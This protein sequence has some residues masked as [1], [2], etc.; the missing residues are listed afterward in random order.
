MIIKN[1]EE[2]LRIRCEAVR[3]EEI[4]ELVAMLEKELDHSTYIG[5][6]G[7]GLA[8]IQVGTPKNIAIVRLGEYKVDLVNC[9]IEKGY[10]KAIFRDE[11]CLSFPGRV[12]DTMRYQEI[13]VVNNLVY[14]HSFVASGLMA[15]VVAHEIDHMNG[16]LLPDN[17]IPKIKKKVGPNDSCICGSGRKYKKCC[18]NKE[19]YNGK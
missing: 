8:A 14:P 5:Q 19:I 10:D 6:F 11:G 12:E 7:V 16:I 17:A 4:G 3:E 18:Q 1:N 9:R 13:Y 15:V 2:A